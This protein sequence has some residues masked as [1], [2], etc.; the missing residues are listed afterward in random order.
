[1]RM[2]IKRTCAY[3][4]SKGKSDDFFVDEARRDKEATRGKEFDEKAVC[5]FSEWER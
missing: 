1:M 4:M 5:T 2:P 3:V